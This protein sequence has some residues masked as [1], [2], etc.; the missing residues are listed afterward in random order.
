MSSKAINIL[1]YL[2]RLYSSMF[3]SET[4]S[5]ICEYSINALESLKSFKPKLFGL[6][7]KNWYLAP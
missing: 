5:I 2:L 1:V 6:L 4:L 7:I 3:Y